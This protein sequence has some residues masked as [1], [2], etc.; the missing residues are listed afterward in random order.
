MS[1]LEKSPLELDRSH[2]GGTL[3]VAIWEFKPKSES[4]MEFEEAYGSNGVWARFFRKSP[5]FVC[6]LL[7]SQKEGKY[8]TLDFW[9]SEQSY[10]DFLKSNQ[11]EYQVLDERCTLL[12]ESE[13][14]IGEYSL[15]GDWPINR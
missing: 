13:A 3:F 10:R 4:K 8:V 6:T 14:R 12:T 2:N 7:L 15:I 5:E 11:E 9:K 1:G